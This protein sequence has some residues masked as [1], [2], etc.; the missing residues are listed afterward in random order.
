M[1]T[2]RHQSKKHGKGKEKE[3]SSCTAKQSHA[4]TE[5]PSGS[6]ENLTAQGGCFDGFSAG[7]AESLNSFRMQPA[8]QLDPCK[9]ISIIDT[10]SSHEC[11][12]P[13]VYDREVDL[14]SAIQSQ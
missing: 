1:V 9:A 6:G 10:R 14:I 2:T 13:T 8:R 4:A 7:Q 11:G 12:L 3:H 5:I